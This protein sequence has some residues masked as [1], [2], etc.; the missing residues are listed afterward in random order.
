MATTKT[1]TANPHMSGRNRRGME[2][3][4]EVGAMAP[5]VDAVGPQE[6]K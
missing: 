6:A 5:R 1:P 2:M 3:N 4:K